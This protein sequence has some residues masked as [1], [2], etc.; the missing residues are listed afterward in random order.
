MT[1]VVKSFSLDL[2]DDRDLVAEIAKLPKGELSKVVREALRVHFLGQVQDRLTLGDVYQA[3]KQ[4]ERKLQAGT[5]TPGGRE[6][7]ALDGQSDG[8]APGCE[9]A[10]ANLDAWQMRG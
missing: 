9:A 1:K 6:T 2:D 8:D 7:E 5:I 10:A 4:L 3:V